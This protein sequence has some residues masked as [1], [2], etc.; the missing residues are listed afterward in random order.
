MNS[1]SGP[2][3]HFPFRKIPVQGIAWEFDSADV[4]KS[5]ENMLSNE[6]SPPEF[7]N[8]FDIFR[9]LAPIEE[10]SSFFDEENCIL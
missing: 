4:P 6:I 3:Q 5:F 7:T 8:Q 9:D 2:K 1:P 10:L